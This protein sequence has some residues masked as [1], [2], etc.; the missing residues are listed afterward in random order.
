MKQHSVRFLCGALAFVC[1][2]FAQRPARA[3]FTDATLVAVSAATL[4]LG[5]LAPSSIATVFGSKLATTTAIATDTD[6]NLPGV[7]LPLALGGTTVRVQG[8]LARLLFVSPQQ[9]NFIVPPVE[10]QSLF[11]GSQEI[12][13]L[14]HRPVP[15]ERFAAARAAG[16]G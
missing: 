5:P 1:V 16:S 6:P 8:Q 9:V 10:T 7:Q 15:T 3:Q 13:V 11:R 12:E 2:L 4:R 14:Y